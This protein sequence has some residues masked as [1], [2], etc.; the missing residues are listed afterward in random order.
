MDTICFDALVIIFN[1][2]YALAVADFW[3]RVPTDSRRGPT[4]ID[5]RANW[6]ISDY[7]AMM[8][9]P[10][11][12][13]NAV[14]K[15]WREVIN[16]ACPLLPLSR[17]VPDHRAMC[18]LGLLGIFKGIQAYLR[19]EVRALIFVNKRPNTGYKYRVIIFGPYCLI[20]SFNMGLSYY[21]QVECRAQR[22]FK[23]DAADKLTGVANFAN[24][25]RASAAETS[26]AIVNWNDWR[27]K[28]SIKGRLH[29]LVSD[30]AD[31]D[32]D[33]KDDMVYK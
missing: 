33:N 25:A 26:F 28:R 13:L 10:Y 23:S 3:A 4:M 24:L 21:F 27:F 14:C 12:N 15:R 22:L 29:T 31:S 9:G 1:Y 7:P 11:H 18:R 20:L 16:V 6:P 19:P 5:R 32:D 30:D 17:F 2:C 8:Y